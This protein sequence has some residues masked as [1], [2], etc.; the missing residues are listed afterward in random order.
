MQEGD[1]VES[2]VTLGEL[3]EMP[4]E[5][6]CE[7]ILDSDRQ[8][9]RNACVDNPLHPKCA[10]PGFAERLA[11]G[12]AFNVRES[13]CDVWSRQTLWDD[14]WTKVSASSKATSDAWVKH[15]AKSIS[16]EQRDDWQHPE[17]RPIDLQLAGAAFSQLFLWQEP[18]VLKV[19]KKRIAGIGPDEDD[20]VNQVFIRAFNTYWSPRSKRR[21]QG[22]SL[23]STFLHTIVRRVCADYLDDRDPGVGEEE[24]LPDPGAAAPPPLSP[25][26][27][28]E[29]RRR[30]KAYLRTLKPHEAVVYLLVKRRKMQQNEL[31]RRF[32]VS[33]A[34]I[35]QWLTSAE[36]KIEQCLAKSS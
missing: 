32:G 36:R 13:Y 8:G 33:G 19:I 30:F 28:R 6:R 18:F 12:L 34:A 23:I 4:I 17:H 2:T 24:M 25:T 27:A 7:F 35:S 29:V 5:R 10:E 3:S 11:W 14:V 1:L 22:V 16:C 31:A 26:E 9:L 21:F 15:L 20:L